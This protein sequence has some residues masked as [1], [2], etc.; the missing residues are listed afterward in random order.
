VSRATVVQ[1]ESGEG[2]IKLSTMA[3]LAEALGMSPM[4]LLM[5]ESELEGMREMLTAPGRVNEISSNMTEDEA[6]PVG[7]LPRAQKRAAAIGAGVAMAAGLSGAAAVGAAIGTIALPGIGTAIGAVLGSFLG[8]HVGKAGT[9]ARPDFEK[10]R[11]RK[12]T[13]SPVVTRG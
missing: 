8:A 9:Q 5:G 12:G 4:L 1:I 3:D 2:D 6:K 13:H 10:A 7:S 11:R